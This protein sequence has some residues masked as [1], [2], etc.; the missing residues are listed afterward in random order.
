MKIGI[1]IATFAL[2]LLT[3][4]SR[5]IAHMKRK[6][7]GDRLSNYLVTGNFEEFDKYVNSDEAKR[8]LPAFN[9][10]YLKL[11]KSIM[12]NDMESVGKRLAKIER[13]KLNDAQ[14]ET[15][16]SRAFY[17]YVTEKEEEKAKRYYKLLNE[18]KNIKNREM[19]DRTYD[20]YIKHGHAY[21]DDCL[22]KFENGSTNV[23]VYLAG[24]ISTMYKN[25]NDEEN[26]QKYLD[27]ISEFIIENEE[28]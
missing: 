9:L 6:K 20:I 25:M 15:V 10:E 18:L 17:F 1:L 8:L 27:F 26:A 21:L 3:N 5:I 12:Q 19:L 24:L 4:G 14:K 22:E 2:I 7:V 13:M 28:K 16:Y 23:K 11:N